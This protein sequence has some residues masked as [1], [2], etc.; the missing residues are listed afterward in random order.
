MSSMSL[1]QH[2]TERRQKPLISLPMP[3]LR[4]RMGK[5]KKPPQKPERPHLGQMIRGDL[6]SGTNRLIRRIAKS[7][8]RKL[9]DVLKLAVQIRIDRPDL[10]KN[11]TPDR[12]AQNTR[13]C[14][15]VTKPFRL[16]I[17]DMAWEAG[18]PRSVWIGLVLRHALSLLDEFVLI[19]YLRSGEDVTNYILQELVNDPKIQ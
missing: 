1:N 5:T 11:L 2:R 12:A 18:I 6:S 13:C 19:N 10:F 17:G 16:K 14:F 7:S 15:R 9:I 4:S 8:S 3:K